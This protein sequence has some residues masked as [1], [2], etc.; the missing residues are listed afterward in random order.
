M[1]WYAMIQFSFI[2]LTA[3]HNRPAGAVMTPRACCSF[4]WR[5]RWRSLSAR[6]R[7]VTDDSPRKRPLLHCGWSA[8]TSCPT[9]FTAAP[10]SASDADPREH[11]AVF[12][13]PLW[14]WSG[15]FCVWICFSFQSLRADVAAD[16]NALSFCFL[17]F[18]QLFWSLLVSSRLLG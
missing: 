4:K 18:H 13:P 14:C 9:G 15:L 1:L 3:V 8:T 6:S 11:S 12:K 5:S 10:S 2:Y 7:R 17:L 16:V